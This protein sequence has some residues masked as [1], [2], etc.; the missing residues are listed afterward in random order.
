MEK[1]GTFLIP[2]LIWSYD[3]NQ[4]ADLHNFSRLF[5]SHCSESSVVY[6]G[7]SGGAKVLGKLSVRGV[8]LNLANSRARAYCACS[9]CGGGGGSLNVFSLIYLLSFLSPSLGDDLI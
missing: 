9:R 6:A 5:T 4:S 8:L 3:K 2:L 7:W 1:C